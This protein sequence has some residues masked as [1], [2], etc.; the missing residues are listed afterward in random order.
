MEYSTNDSL[1]RFF[2]VFFLKR[3]DDWH[4]LIPL[5]DQSIVAQRVETTSSVYLLAHLPTY[6]SIVHLATHPQALDGGQTW[7]LLLCLPNIVCLLAASGCLFIGTC[8]MLTR[9]KS[10]PDVCF[11]FHS[12]R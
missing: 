12:L 10:W 4:A 5:Q 7:F 2:C 11:S 3:C 1:L 6:L 9:I 8:T